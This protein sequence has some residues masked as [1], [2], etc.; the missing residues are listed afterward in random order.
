MAITIIITT[1]NPIAN[2][3]EQFLPLLN[4]LKKN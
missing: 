1:L 2:S 4:P 3:K